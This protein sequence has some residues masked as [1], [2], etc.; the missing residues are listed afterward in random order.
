MGIW[1]EYRRE[2]TNVF[3]QVRL[4]QEPPRQA[5]DYAQAR[6]SESWAWHSRG[7]ARRTAGEN[8]GDKEIAKP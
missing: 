4:L 7:I 5:L 6:M 1:L 3:D 8:S 2:L